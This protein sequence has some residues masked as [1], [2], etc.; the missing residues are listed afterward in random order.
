M[1]SSAGGP[2]SAVVVAAPRNINNLP[3]NHHHNQQQQ[4]PQLR[5]SL[6]QTSS[7]RISNQSNQAAQGSHPPPAASAGQAQR[8]LRGNSQVPS[9]VFDE[10]P[11][12]MSEV[13]T[14]ATGFRRGIKARSSLPIVRTPS[15]TQDRSLGLV[16][17]QYRNETKRALLPN[18]I[19]SMDTVKALFVRS[20]PRQLT[21]QYLDSRQVRIYAHDPN[22]DMFYELEDLRDVR[23]RTVLRIY[24]QDMVNGSWQ[25]VGGIRP[26]HP[27]ILH[28]QP[29]AYLDNDP[30]YFSEPEFES[31]FQNQHIHRAR[32]ERASFGHPGQQQQQMPSSSA[33][34]QYYGTIIMPPA[35]RAQTLGRGNSFSGPTQ[36]GCGVASGGGG[37]AGPPQPP[38][39]SKGAYAGEFSASFPL[40]CANAAL[41]KFH[42]CASLLNQS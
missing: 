27:Q 5:Q 19:T 18:E 10:D 32:K 37:P 13:E 41:K 28:Q 31:E 2:N 39:R 33:Q 15:K 26:E 11:G 24:E 9:A 7:L 34:S 20:F 42:S 17:L 12:I 25:P 6:S 16:F 8:G 1:A 29:P 40:S 4:T 23:D 35:Y 22:K 14:S 36:N 30:S 3:N 21:M 38:E